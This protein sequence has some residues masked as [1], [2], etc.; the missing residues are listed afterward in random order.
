MPGAGQ[1][2]AVFM[3]ANLLA[4]FLDDAA[5]WLLPFSLLAYLRRIGDVK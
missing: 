5:H 2:F 3:L 1:Q 4:T